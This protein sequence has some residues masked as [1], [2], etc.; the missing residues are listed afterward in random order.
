MRIDVVR[1]HLSLVSIDNTVIHF[2]MMRMLCDNQM[3]YWSYFQKIKHCKTSSTRWVTSYS[4]WR[5]D[6]KTCT[7]TSITVQ[8]W[9]QL[10]SHL[11]L[12]VGD[13]S[14]SF[15]LALLR[16]NEAGPNVGR[17]AL[18][19][20]DFQVYRESSASSKRL[21]N[22]PWKVACN[23]GQTWDLFDPYVQRLLQ[24][25]MPTIRPGLN[26]RWQRGI[27]SGMH[28]QLDNQWKRQVFCHSQARQKSKKL[29]G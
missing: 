18:L 12:T 1:A 4:L 14:L 10:L 9:I 2:E 16:L 7:C 13:W 8:T 27:W 25:A 26:V 6:C 3:I 17:L 5:E 15:C 23:I 20:D 28:A 21:H 19:P 29:Q 22:L 24:F 11:V